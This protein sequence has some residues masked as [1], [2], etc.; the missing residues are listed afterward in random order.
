MAVCSHIANNLSRG[1][2]GHVLRSAPMVG[3]MLVPRLAAGFQSVAR[4]P[5]SPTRVSLHP[6]AYAQTFTFC[7]VARIFLWL[8]NISPIVQLSGYV[9]PPPG[10]LHVGHPQHLRDETL[11]QAG[12][13]IAEKGTV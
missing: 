5:T 6:L 12:S 7:C 4:A 10:A 13:L 9:R 3:S 2:S 1:R 8:G 11:S